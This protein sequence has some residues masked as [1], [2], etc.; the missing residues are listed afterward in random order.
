[1]RGFGIKSEQQRPDERL[2][3]SA[4]A[5]HFS[6]TPGF[7]RVLEY[8][9]A[10]SRLNGLCPYDRVITGVNSGVNEKFVPTCPFM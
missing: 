8:A 1:M 4:A 6:L 10:G 7:S 3:R 2:V 9:G 5:F